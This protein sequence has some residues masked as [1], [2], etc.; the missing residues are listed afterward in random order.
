MPD[1]SEKPRSVEPLYRLDSSRNPAGRC[2]TAAW[3]I[4]KRRSF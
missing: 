1:L 2:R 4:S 3:S